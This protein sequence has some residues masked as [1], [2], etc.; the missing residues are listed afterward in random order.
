MKRTEYLLI[1][2]IIVF[3]ISRELFGMLEIPGASY[4][5][6]AAV[7]GMIVLAL[8]YAVQGKVSIYTIVLILLAFENLGDIFLL[9]DWPAQLVIK[10]IGLGGTVLFPIVL[11]FASF[12][13]W[14]QEK[15]RYLLFIAIV[16]LVQ[17]ALVMSWGE[18]LDTFRSITFYVLFAV[19]TTL[20]LNK[21]QL[22][23]DLANV[24]TF[25]LVGAA[26]FLIHDISQLVN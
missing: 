11:L 14:T 3:G 20:K 4:L 21:V 19:I 13:D 26:L 17:I 24:L 12:K 5:F 16:L 23:N 2:L 7:T 9:Q 15:S 1:G 6:F 25:Y 18:R 8:F 10:T 22:R